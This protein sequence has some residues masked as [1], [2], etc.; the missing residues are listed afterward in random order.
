MIQRFGARRPQRRLCAATIGPRDVVPFDIVFYFPPISLIWFTCVGGD[1]R[2]AASAGHEPGEG[3]IRRRR[4][5]APD[6]D[7]A[8]GP[9]AADLAASVLGYYRWMTPSLYLFVDM[10]WL[11]FLA[12]TVIQI[13]AVDALLG[14]RLR[15]RL[16]V[17]APNSTR[18]GYRHLIV[19]LTAFSWASSPRLR[20]QSIV[21]GDEPKYLRFLENW[22]RGGGF[23]ISDSPAPGV[24][25]DAPHLEKPGALRRR[26]WRTVAGAREECA[27]PCPGGSG[28]ADQPDDADRCRQPGGAA[29]MEVCIRDIIP[30]QL[31]LLPGYVIDRYFELDQRART[32]C[33]P[34]C[35]RPTRRCS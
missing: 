14:G 12:V 21:V 22:H 7:G 4:D 18:A 9:A 29:F 31:F 6:A 23:D 26:R 8:V 17:Q 16:E 19:L 33:R 24:T 1:P 5:R 20:F 25:D 35:M 11:F 10:R 34:T 2:P 27:P 13:A 15:M 30:A 28:R 32:W 3:I